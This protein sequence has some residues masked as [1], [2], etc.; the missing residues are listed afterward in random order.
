ME[1]WTPT[2]YALATGALGLVVI[3]LIAVVSSRRKGK[4]GSGGG[5]DDRAGN[6]RQ[7]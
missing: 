4:S 5:R 1:N 6:P 2:D 7:H 3:I